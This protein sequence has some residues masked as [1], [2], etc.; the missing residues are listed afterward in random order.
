MLRHIE[1]LVIS[2]TARILRSHAYKCSGKR[3]TP[4]ARVDRQRGRPRIADA[5]TNGVVVEGPQAAW[6][7]P[8]VSEAEGGSI[9]SG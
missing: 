1:V 9:G 6:E 2:G 4:S 8:T 3:P 7:S 5:G